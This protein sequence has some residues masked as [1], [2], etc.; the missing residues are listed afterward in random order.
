MANYEE[1]LVVT[2]DAKLG[3]GVRRFLE[4]ASIGVVEANSIGAALTKLKV[5]SPHAM[6]LD[7]D[8]PRPELR[9]FLSRRESI[10]SLAGVPF[11]LLGWADQ[12]KTIQPGEFGN[13]APTALL[14]LPLDPGPSSDAIRK[15]LRNR[16]EV[17]VS[18]EEASE[19]LATFSGSLPV[20]LWSVSE[21]GFSFR[22]WVKFEPG[23]LL[24]S[25]LKI[26][27][28]ES[29]GLD[30]ALWVVTGSDS[31]TDAV[32]TRATFYGVTLSVAKK[33]RTRL[34]RQQ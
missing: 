2:A 32:E 21:S 34:G 20:N 12:L 23:T 9:H 8:L 15:L 11:A 5:F 28:F 13:E 16:E 4:A 29:L 30:Q 19:G 6:I 1:I 24:N 7:V 14:S 25:R 18:L 33:V 31:T 22:S 17:S 26:P 27:L 3:L 10:F